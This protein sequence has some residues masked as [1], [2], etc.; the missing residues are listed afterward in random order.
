MMVLVS[1]LTLDSRL[2]HR[3][4][5]FEYVAMLQEILE[6]DPT[7]QAFPPV[8]L[9]QEGETRWLWD[10]F[11]RLAAYRAAGRAEI[12]AKLEG[13]S[14]HDAWVRSLGAN[15]THGLRR[16]RAEIQAVLDKALADPRVGKMASREIARICGVSHTFVLQQNRKS[17]IV[18]KETVYRDN[19]LRRE[20]IASPFESS[21][22][23]YENHCGNVSRLPPR[24]EIQVLPEAEEGQDKFVSRHPDGKFRCRKCQEAFSKPHWHCECGQHYRYDMGGCKYCAE[25]R[26][27]WMTRMWAR[28]NLG[29]LAR[30]ADELGL[31]HSTEEALAELKK[32]FAG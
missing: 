4:V 29:Q 18:N 25:K 11:Q 16:T 21:S 32:V 30:M 26:P 19:P 8:G 24:E 3:E 6:A 27:P 14:F 23:N 31:Y 22:S 5:N 12:L 7:L 10:G 13:G 17:P 9:I 20:E 1:S 15:A 2:Q 28:N